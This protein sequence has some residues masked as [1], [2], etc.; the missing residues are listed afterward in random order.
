MTNFDTAKMIFDVKTPMRDGVLLSSDVYLPND[1]G[2]FPAVLIRTPYDNNGAP[3]IEKGRRLAQQGYACVIQDVRWRFDSGGTY[4]P[5]KNEDLDGFDAQEWMGEQPWC[6]GK[7]GMSGGSYVGLTQWASSW[8][9]SQYLKCMAPRVAPSDYWDSP[10]YVGGAMGI[11]VMMTW[12]WRTNAHTAQ[13]IEYYN[14]NHLFRTL[15]LA[16]ADKAAGRDLEFWEDWIQ[17]DSYGDYWQRMS[18]EDKWGQIKAPALNLGGWYD[19]YAKA[20]FVNF[21]GL[22]HHGGSEE[23]KQSKL[24]VGPWPHQ[25]SVSTQTGDVDF[26]EASLM[27]LEALELRWFDYWLKGED[28]GIVDEAPLRLFIM[29][30]NEWRDEWEWPLARTDWQKWHLHSDGHA[31]SLIGDGALCTT[32]P[33]EEQPDQFTYDPDNPVVTVGGANCCSPHIV[34]WGPLDQGPVEMRSD[35]L[36]YTS[37]PMEEDLEVT[38]P[39]KLVLFAATDGRDT[40]WTGKLVDVYP[41]GY[42]MNLTDSILRARFREDIRNP[43]LLEPGKV[44]EYEIDLWVVGNVFRKGHR[45]R[46]EVSSSNFPRFDRNPNTGNPF[47]RDA[48]LR[49]AQQQVHHSTTYPSHL[50]L[51]VIPK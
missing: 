15:P 6:N 4:Y 10:N 37:A 27:D 45:V 9:G 11:G 17:N 38:G 50:L 1:E 24:V 43:S 5:F 35:V 19:L 46:L 20:T 23:A 31:N 44:Y 41:D 47:G 28:N 13:S 18:N 40:D 16:D 26:G 8:H 30:T 7:I 48:E 33:G 32:P 22:R 21:N 12:G 39:I 49:I 29:G 42:A 2:P 36:C 34:P 51:P 3:N 25:L 14:W